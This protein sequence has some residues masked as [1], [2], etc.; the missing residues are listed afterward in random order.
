[1]IAQVLHVQLITSPELQKILAV[2]SVS[3]SKCGLQ[4]IVV[5][6]D[7]PGNRYFNVNLDILSNIDGQWI[8][9]DKGS[10]SRTKSKRRRNCRYSNWC[11]HLA[12]HNN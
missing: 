7:N 6:L 10:N 3:K 12:Y 9:V 2:L 11:Y 8:E 4:T 5:W 1:M